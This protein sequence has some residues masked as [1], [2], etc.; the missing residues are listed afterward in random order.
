M[1][2]KIS[3][4][5]LETGLKAMEK[6][7][8]GEFAEKG[9]MDDDYKAI[10]TSYDELDDILTRHQGGIF[11]G[12]ICELWGSEGAG[13]SSVAMRT[14]GMAQKLGLHCAWIDAEHSF[15]PDLAV[16]NRCDLDKLVRIQMTVGTGD[17]VRLLNVS[18]VLNRIFQA[19][20]SA[21]FSLVVLDSVA[22]LMPERIVANDYDPTSKGISELARAMS[23][24]LPKIAAACAEKECTVIFINQ[25]RMKPGDR[26]SP[27]DTPGGRALKFYAAQRISVDKKFGQSALVMQ[28]DADGIDEVVGHYARVK[29]VKNK[30]NQPYYDALEIPI[31]Y[32]EYFPDIAKS[33][34]DLA[35][36]LKVITTRRG[37][38]TWKDDGNAVCQVE[39]ES[40]MLAFIRDSKMEPHLAKCCVE[41]GQG[42]RNMKLKKPILVPGN[43]TKIAGEYDPDK[44]PKKPKSKPTLNTELDLDDIVNE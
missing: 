32:K 34:Y 15:S 14:V 3:Q 42:E 21:V 13:K 27:Y 30:R 19:V 37:M 5:A 39:G 26:Y 11:L 16:L 6:S 41:M 8:G 24:Q 35:R 2:K 36:K 33:C 4:K 1:Y 40:D 22:A 7:F 38:L 18:E 20:W 23:E 12:G 17:K 25:V 31:Y 44:P 10:P 29:V 9:L 43:I 28:Q